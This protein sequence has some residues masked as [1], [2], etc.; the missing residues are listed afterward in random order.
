MSKEERT[1]IQGLYL[2]MIE[3][4]GAG[5]I[6]NGDNP[7]LSTMSISTDRLGR[8]AKISQ[9]GESLTASCIDDVDINFQYIIR[10]AETVS[11]VTGTGLISHPGTNG[12][13]AELSPGTG[14]GKAQL[15]SKAPVRYRAGHE[16]YCELSWVYR[17]PEANLDQWC[18]FLNS[19]DRWCVGYQGL[20]FG[21]LFREGGNDTF[22]N[23]N[24]FSIDKLD[25][26]TVKVLVVMK[27]IHR[28]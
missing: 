24:D 6:Y 11:T 15:L 1:Q 25:G 12:S 21:L 2:D 3:Y 7:R 8:T 13:Y 16:V 20:D 28:L 14:V 17:T 22:I 9:K 18:G 26:K 4:D 5:D 19:V 10:T 27:L 23:R